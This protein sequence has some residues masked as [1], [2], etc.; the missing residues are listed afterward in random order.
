MHSAMD[1]EDF[2]MLKCFAQ[3]AT[4]A[5]AFYVGLSRISDYKHHWQDVLV[6]LTQGTIVAIIVCKYMWPAIHKNFFANAK[7]NNSRTGND[8]DL[9]RELDRVRY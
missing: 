7:L 5:S 9:G 8:E 3:V 6:G 4:I 1:I 2:G